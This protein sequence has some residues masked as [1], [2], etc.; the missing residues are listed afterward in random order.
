MV[1]PM[2]KAGLWWR[3]GALSIDWV[4]GTIVA[5][6]IS[7]FLLTILEYAFEDGKLF[8]RLEKGP[9]KHRRFEATNT[10]RVAIAIV[11]SFGFFVFCLAFNLKTQATPGRMIFRLRIR[12]RD[13]LTPTT[14]QIVVSSLGAIP[15]GL[16]FPI[17]LAYGKGYAV[18]DLVALV[19]GAFF[20]G[21]ARK[22]QTPF[23]MLARTVVIRQRRARKTTSRPKFEKKIAPNPYI[24]GPPI[25]GKQMFFG[26]ENDL[27]FIRT[28][29]DNAVL[30]LWGPRR[31]GKTSLFMQICSRQTAVP[32]DDIIPAYIDAQNLVM[33]I[34]NNDAD[35]YR[36]LAAAVAAGAGDVDIDLGA[37]DFSQ[38]SAAASLKRVIEQ[39]IGKDGDRRLTF[40]VDEFTLLEKRI[41]EGT[42]TENVP[43]FLSGLVNGNAN[44][45]IVLTGSRE[46]DPETMPR[47]WLLIQNLAPDLCQQVGVLLEEDCRRLITEPV[48]ERLEVAPEVVDLIYRLTGGHPFFTQFICH[49]MVIH[50]NRQKQAYIDIDDL[51]A[52]VPPTVEKMPDET[53]DIWSRTLS[54][55]QRW[56]LS[57]MGEMLEESDDT[58]TESALWRQL[59]QPEYELVMTKRELHAGLDGLIRVDILSETRRE[60]YAFNIDLLRH[61]I[62][63]K[64]PVRSLYAARQE[65]AHE[66]KSQTTETKEDG[67]AS[68]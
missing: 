62:R 19:V 41:E 32:F 29:L 54:E 60:E 15:V 51:E 65:A 44:I 66:P 63:K 58:I 64:H 40:F 18:T 36:E 23:E 10:G 53:L 12:S 42:L 21:L 17:F 1:V 45:S 33:G 8:K 35:F 67:A 26:R 4:L 49:Q 61:W 34:V 31:T 11:G 57:V 5:V 14:R 48:K 24:F 20:I 56:I 28:H 59:R 50:A 6:V 52:F 13:G 47:I 22:R 38:K 37:L 55:D 46:A 2:R 27:R 30:L 7:L 3:L 9:E 68:E 25:R 43:V 16:A 39:A